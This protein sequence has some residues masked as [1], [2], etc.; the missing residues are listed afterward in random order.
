M[1]T[2]TALAT[3]VTTAEYKAKVIKAFQDFLWEGTPAEFSESRQWVP[4]WK[5]TY[6]QAALANNVLINLIDRPGQAPHYV[7]QDG[8]T[9]LREFY[10]K[11]FRQF[12]TTQ[13]AEEHGTKDASAIEKFIAEVYNM[14]NLTLVAIAEYYSR[15]KR[16]LTGPIGKPVPRKKAT[17]EA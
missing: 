2:T 8:K 7:H 16:N 14:D 1:A 17:V 11:S 15:R 5:E 9:T 12:I 10:D 13:Y 3:E 6:K 4:G